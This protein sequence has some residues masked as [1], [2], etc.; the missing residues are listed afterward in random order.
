LRSGLVRTGKKAS[1]Y[2]ILTRWRGWDR[3]VRLQE[4]GP[5]R[6][7]GTGRHK[8]EPVGLLAGQDGKGI[9]GEHPL[10]GVGRGRS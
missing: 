1:R 8:E 7:G 6:W 5:A 9:E 10:T 4:K 3:K 2:R